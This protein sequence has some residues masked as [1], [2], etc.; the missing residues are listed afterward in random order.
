M[1]IVGQINHDIVVNAKIQLL[2]QPNGVN[3]NT[4]SANYVKNWTIAFL[5]TKVATASQDNLIISF[6]GE[7]ITV[8]L[9][10]DTYWVSYAIVINNE[11]DKLFFTG[12]L[13]E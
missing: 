1:R 5:Q 4:L 6:P 9:K 12:F 8:T 2:G 13:V 10:Q 3:R 7:Y 11:I